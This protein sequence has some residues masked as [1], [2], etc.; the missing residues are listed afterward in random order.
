MRTAIEDRLFEL[1]DADKL[2]LT[3]DEIDALVDRLIDTAKVR[4]P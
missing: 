1:K 4:K 3:L 2:P